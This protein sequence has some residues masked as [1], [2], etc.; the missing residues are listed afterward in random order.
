MAAIYEAGRSVRLGS[1][2]KFQSSKLY[3]GHNEETQSHSLILLLQSISLSKSSL[4]R[5]FDST[6][7][8]FP[9]HLAL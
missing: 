6:S 2:N 5:D 1:V 3:N 7:E 4:S 9:S 8:L